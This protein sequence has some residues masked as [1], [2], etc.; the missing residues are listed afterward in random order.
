MVTDKDII[1]ELD[2]WIGT[3]W[4]HG[5]ALKG[6]GADCIQFIIGVA[7]QFQWLP[8]DYTSIKYNK[9]WA[10]HNARS[11]LEEELAKVAS[12][13][14]SGSIDDLNLLKTGDVIIFRFGKCASHA[15]MYVGDGVMV[16]ALIRQF[17]MRD[18]VMKYRTR[19]VSA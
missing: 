8:E 11:I 5:I 13:V 1:A 18:W 6:F 19:F 14:I 10:V 12:R 16:H 4:K 7:K 3:P 17:V 9:D 2:S 15:G